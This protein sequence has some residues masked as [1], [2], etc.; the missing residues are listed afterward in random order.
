M[1]NKI[2]DSFLISKI[3][4]KQSFDAAWQVN[5]VL[6]PISKDMQCLE[7]IYNLRF[8]ADMWLKTITSLTGT[9]LNLFGSSKNGFGFKQ[10]DLD[11]CMT[12]DGLETAEVD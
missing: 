6:M 5:N 2:R 7:A 1:S 8:C 9:K 4:E 11:I 10:S 12:M 3:D